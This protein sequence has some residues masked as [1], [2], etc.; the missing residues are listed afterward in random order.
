MSKHVAI[1]GRVNVGK[2][3][4]FN[5][6]CNKQIALVN[7]QAGTTRDRRTAHVSWRGFEFDLTDCGGV[8]T[9]QL[10]E[11]DSAVNHVSW[12][13]AEAADILLLVVDRKDKN[14]DQDQQILARARKLG[15]PILLVINKLDD[16]K[17]E[18]DIS[19]A[20]S[21]GLDTS[22]K[23]SALHERGIFE[24]LETIVAELG[25]TSSLDEPEVL[26]SDEL[27]L[28]DKAKNKKPIK[29][30][31]LGR[32]NVGKSTLA[33]RWFGKERMI[34]S[35][36][37]G[38]TRDA[39]EDSIYI[40]KEQLTLVD[41]PGIRPQTRILQ[42][43][44]K[45]SVAQSLNSIINSD[46]CL[47]LY[48]VTEGFSHQ[49]G[50]LAELVLEKKKSL[51]IVANKWD[52]L[53]KDSTR[54]EEERKKFYFERPFLQNYDIEFVSSLKGMRT[55]RLL[56]KI[57]ELAKL[58]S[59]KLSVS[60]VTGFVHRLKVTAKFPTNGKRKLTM[61]FGLQVGTNPPRFAFYVNDPEIVSTNFTR[62][63]M[64]R[65]VA[66]YGFRGV[67]LSIVWRKKKGTAARDNW[68]TT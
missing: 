21:I 18:Q 3:T 52:L 25:L 20:Y 50:R 23:I 67:P 41:S 15:K 32:P 33:N 40:N 34:V 38:T 63:I 28:L 37:A 9:G 51:L 8:E 31:L 44:E 48:D 6:I 65:L 1:I 54:L 64:N 12:M 56:E 36:V 66:E 55:Q 22:I 53:E 16:L 43:L 47:L 11:M 26:E 30:L 27:A 60:D 10:A 61:K 57:L 35:A 58:R 42:T 4:L 39:I 46:V 17:H 68:P 59:K 49:D 19:D 14:I 2:S 24:L 62:F 13:A 45:D 7:E 5:R 29:I